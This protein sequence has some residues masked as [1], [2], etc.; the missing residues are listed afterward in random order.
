VAA[1][2]LALL[3]D[4]SLIVRALR[5]LRLFW[6]TSFAA[7]LEYRV[8]FAMAAIS[9]LGH[10]VGAIFALT[11]FYQHGATLGGWSFDEALIVTGFFTFLQGITRTWFSPNLGRIVE[12]V[13]TG[14]LDF[15]LIKPVDSQ[16]W[17]SVRRFSPW[18]LPDLLLG[19]GMVGYAAYRLNLGL[20][21]YLLALGP[22]LLSLVILYSLWFILATT[23]IWCV[24]IYNMTE[25]LQA[26]LAAGR[27]PI[28]A[29]PPG[30][31]RVLFTFVV[32]VA[33]MTTVPA[34]AL[35]GRLELWTLLQAAGFALGLF[36][37]S[38]GFWRFAL[39]YYTSASS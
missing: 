22:V 37:L 13:R 25:V 8:N 21:G 29:F 33:F 26:M 1:G 7:E 5:L 34:E 18:G 14:T 11:L 9:S 38:R 3:G 31:Y 20:Q 17:L 10:F 39:R 27:Y 36:A 16:F 19:L 23:T 4:G 15:V 24:K 6:S 28:Q 2:A 30:L 35:L 12:H 32:P